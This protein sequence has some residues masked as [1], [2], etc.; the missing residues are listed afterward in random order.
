MRT[1]QYLVGFSVLL[2]GTPIDSPEIS[3]R[4]NSKRKNTLVRANHSSSLIMPSLFAPSAVN[5]RKRLYVVTSQMPRSWILPF[6]QGNL[7]TVPSASSPTFQCTQDGCSIF[8]LWARHC[9]KTRISLGRIPSTRLSALRITPA[10]S[11][12]RTC[13]EREFLCLAHF[14]E[15]VAYNH[16]GIVT[17]RQLQGNT[18]DGQAW[19]ACRYRSCEKAVTGERNTPTQPVGLARIA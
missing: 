7:I 14:A 15:A 5:A 19:R 4:T 9:G 17:L 11:P 12:K 3:S 16:A 18:N 8:D 1:V 10:A 6:V 13:L 2:A